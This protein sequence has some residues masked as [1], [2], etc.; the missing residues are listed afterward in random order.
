MKIAVIDYNEIWRELIV[1]GI[2]RYLGTYN[3]VIDVYESGK[4]FIDRQDLYEVVIMDIE[5][6]EMNGFEMAEKYRDINADY[7]LIIITEH[8][9][10][11]RKGYLVNAFRYIDK[12]KME[13]ELE[14]ALTSAQKLLKNKNVIEINV[15]NTGKM[16]IYLK[17]ILYIETEKRNVAIY[18]VEN[19]H[20]CSQSIGYM[21]NILVKD[22]FYRCHKSF[23]VNLD[24]IKSFD[25][26]NI[27]LK[28]GSNIMVSQRRYY[29]FKKKYLDS[30]V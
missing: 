22:G 6:Q 8:I 23:I 12:I 17:E 3:V 10:F 18:T 27:Y 4:A 9:E 28:D 14:E 2:N 30:K 21:E 13:D 20:I 16:Q 15:V 11:S 26:K 19:K 29:E 7:I 24:W 5:M 25:K 1:K